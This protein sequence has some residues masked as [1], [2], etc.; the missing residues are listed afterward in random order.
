MT[1][2]IFLAVIGGL[3]MALTPLPIHAQQ[4]P[5]I[6]TSGM[7][8]ISHDEMNKRGDKVMGFDQSKTTHHFRLRADGG[9]IEITANTDGDTTSRDQIRLHLGHIVK[10]FAAGNFSAPI[11]IHDQTPPGVPVM[12]KLKKVIKY[13]FEATKRGASIHI[14]TRNSRARAA[15][16]E[17][18]RFQITEHKTGDSLEVTPY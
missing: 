1:I 11:L 6:D 4:Q 17:F 14:S 18:L 3:V 15:I 2:R 12:Q 10:M 13:R 9:I 8:G 7:A 5:K 16:Y